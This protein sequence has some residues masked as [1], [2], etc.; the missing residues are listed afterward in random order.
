LEC[1]ELSQFTS[2]T[3]RGFVEKFY[4]VLKPVNRRQLPDRNNLCHHSTRHGL[5][6]RLSR[7]QRRREMGTILI[8]LLVLLLLGS[9]PSWPYSRNWGYS[10]SGLFGVLLLVV[11]VLVLVGR[12]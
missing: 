7:S 2:P 4:S 5:C 8:I 6:D 11:I 1:S 12:L 3:S 9:V 10:P